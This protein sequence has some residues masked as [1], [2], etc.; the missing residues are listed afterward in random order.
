MQP[1]INSLITL[2]LPNVFM[3]TPLAASG[4]HDIDGVA[5]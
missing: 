5:C 1:Y 2:L 3:F 4:G